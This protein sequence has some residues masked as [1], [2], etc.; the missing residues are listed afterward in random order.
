MSTVHEDAPLARASLP[1]H[2]QSIQAPPKHP[3]QSGGETKLTP[4]S[5]ST[6]SWGRS[7]IPYNSLDF[8]TPTDKK[9]G[10]DYTTSISTQVTETPSSSTARDKDTGIDTTIVP[11]PEPKDIHPQQL[12]PP[13]SVFTLAENVY[14]HPSSV[15]R[16]QDFTTPG[17]SEGTSILASLLVDYI[18]ATLRPEL[19]ISQ[20]S[21]LASFAVVT[22]PK[23][24]L[25]MLQ[26]KSAAL[27]FTSWVFLQP[28]T[29]PVLE[30]HLCPNL[31]PGLILNEHARA[32]VG[33]SSLLR[34]DRIT[35]ANFFVQWFYPS[36]A[37]P[38]MSKALQ[39]Y[40]DADLTAIN[41]TPGLL[42]SRMRLRNREMVFNPPKWYR[43]SID[44]STTPDDAYTNTTQMQFSLAPDSITPSSSLQLSIQELRGLPFPQQRT[45]FLSILPKLLE[46]LTT[47]EGLNEAFAYVNGASAQELL[48]LT[49]VDIF[50]KTF[51]PDKAADAQKQPPPLTITD[52][53]TQAT[54]PAT[55]L[56][57]HSIFLRHTTPSSRGEPNYWNTSPED[58]LQQWI[59][60]VLPVLSHNNHKLYMMHSP[61]DRMKDDREL[62]TGR[63]LS[64]NS[65]NFYIYN[66]RSPR[67]LQSFEFWVKS[68]CPNLHD[69]PSSLKMGPLAPTYISTVAAAS[70]WID[71]LLT[72]EVGTLPCVM[73]EYSIDRDPD[74]IITMELEDRLARNNISV[75]TNSF[76]TTT[77][78]VGD[79]TNST[80]VRVK[81]LLSK[82]EH[83]S[84]IQ[85]AFTRLAKKTITDEY[86]VTSDYH[87]SPINYYADEKTDRRLSAAIVRQQE[88]LHSL[89][90]TI[91][92]GFK[93]MDPFS[94]VP[95]QTMDVETSRIVP[96][97]KSLAHL[98]LLG[99]SLL[100]DGS[101]QPSPVI[102]VTTNEEGTRI[103]LTAHRQ[104]ASELLQYT[105][106]IM[107][108]M[109]IWADHST[110]VTCAVEEAKN[111]MTSHIPSNRSTTRADM[112]AAHTTALPVVAPQPPSANS[113][114]SLA[115]S[116][117]QQTQ[118]P[119][120]SL[121]ADL[122]QF[123]AA[124]EKKLDALSLNNPSKED[125]LG[126]ISASME[127]TL[128]SSLSS[129]SANAQSLITTFMAE[130]QDTMRTFLLSQEAV[131]A[132]L[133]A[134]IHE[135][136]KTTLEIR[137]LLQTYEV[138]AREHTIAFSKMVEQNRLLQLAVEASNH[139]LKQLMTEE[140][141]VD[142]PTRTSTW[143][144]PSTV[145]AP[146]LTSTQQPTQENI[147][148]A[149]ST[150][151]IGGF[152]KSFWSSLLP[153]TTPPTPVKNI[154][155][156]P[157]PT[158]AEDEALNKKAR[159]VIS[160]LATMPY[161]QSHAMDQKSQ[162]I[163]EGEI[164]F[165]NDDQSLPPATAPTCH[166]CNQH[167]VGLMY[168]D[169]CTSPFDL[170][171]DN[172]LTW[173]K[174]S[175][176]RVCRDC[177]NKPNPTVEP[178]SPI[179][180]EDSNKLPSVTSPDREP[181]ESPTDDSPSSSSR[182]TTSSLESYSPVK[183][184]FSKTSKPNLLSK[185]KSSKS[186]KPD[187][188][189][190]RSPPKTRSRTSKVPEDAYDLG[191]DDK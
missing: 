26:S 117:L 99:S 136:E 19:S 79:A 153:S 150:P 96:N 87:F 162:T 167:D 89:T 93:N 154:P 138:S 168:C 40:T 149:S 49:N 191:E 155:S 119:D 83:M 60:A 84:E 98:I 166:L 32:R 86:L 131:V 187:T 126:I 18:C 140:H 41:D 4:L 174:E 13:P 15:W 53:Q 1:T 39:S 74:N 146:P 81:C 64:P 143:P 82:E 178:Q 132:D 59:D 115:S 163:E 35:L 52:T 24:L 160:L 185:L 129:M 2:L 23:R 118:L 16:I 69:L 76:Y 188:A 165:S 147:P 43:L 142:R 67:R 56:F 88:F 57:V 179:P 134:R 105:A 70:I 141:A 133:Q 176:E 68:T 77:C 6:T 152:S 112:N 22:S 8:T 177:I 42:V 85:S 107:S 20:R 106:D 11:R 114:T 48:A 145:I 61:Y 116:N 72:Y 172:C 80:F 17:T 108:F 159:G 14:K 5:S 12:C 104:E 63:E 110:N 183:K 90:K 3:P 71:I 139:R 37:G 156:L 44:P 109:K 92:L 101:L 190:K 33:Q 36:A 175:S 164:V 50:I 157:A 21:T 113:T 123:Q 55:P 28:T 47:P 78:N 170:Y 29:P 10:G 122:L 161:T 66:I 148:T 120:S 182:K 34:G 31:T 158:P 144:P 111:H 95:L 62:N 181:S 9:T 97:S 7:R 102:R 180:P 184:I 171:H 46:G 103:Y 65:L 186:Q 45:A 58:I 124:T 38:G 75:P 73:L 25:S 127:P 173:I 135:G 137:G 169:R 189:H 54:Q 121:R 91:L 151:N 125:I 51:L 128:T 100:T 130:Q 94:Y 27:E 30:R